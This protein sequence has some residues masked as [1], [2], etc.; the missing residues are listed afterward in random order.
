MSEKI[1]DLDL[2]RI[3]ELRDLARK[4]G[5]NAPTSKKKET[6][7]GEIKKIMNGEAVPFSD[8]SNKGRPVRNSGS[9]FDVV[10]L[11][12]PTQ[13]EFSSF[14]D[15]YE[16]EIN[17]EKMRFMVNMEYAEYNSDENES[18]EHVEGLIEI[19]PEGYGVLHVQ[20][21]YKEN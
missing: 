19:K 9:S 8:K 12:L 5:V 17:Q 7:I 13:E 3:H 21:L 10:D 11:I 20:G 14:D 18:D 16:Y 1:T 2:L 15:S 6:L 4:M